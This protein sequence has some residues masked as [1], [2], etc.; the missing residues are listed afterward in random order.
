MSLLPTCVI[1]D[2]LLRGYNGDCV[3]K[4]CKKPCETC[5]GDVAHC[6]HPLREDTSL[7]EVIG[8][9]FGERFAA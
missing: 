9:P 8:D 4:R 2:A 5:G 1:C 6:R 3:C 7:T